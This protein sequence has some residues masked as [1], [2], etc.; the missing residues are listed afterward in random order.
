MKRILIVNNNMHIGGVQKS[1]LNLLNEIHADYDIT[2]LLFYNGGELLKDV[3]GDVK[4]I[5]P[6]EPLRYW[7]MFKGDAQNFRDRLMRSFWAGLTRVTGRNFSMRLACLFQKN[8]RGFD[9]AISFLHS[10]PVK[11]F[12]GGCNEFVLYRTD[13][14]RK[15]TFLHCDF[16]EIKA[17][18][19]Y[20]L[21]IYRQ[22]DTIAACSQGCRNAFLKVAPQ[23]AEKTVGVPN[24]QNYSLIRQMAKNQPVR[25]KDG[26]LN[27]VTVARFGREKGILRAIN[28]VAGLGNQAGDIRYYIIGDGI[29]YQEA[30]TLI[31]DKGL[32]D[33]VFLTGA[34]ENPYGYM[35][36]ADILLIPSVS[37]AA[38]MVVNE[39]ASLGTP[40]L[41]TETSSAVEMVQN[42]GFGW[43]CPNSR[44]GITE[45]IRKLLINPKEIQEK[46]NRIRTVNFNNIEARKKFSELI[47]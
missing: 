23:F 33:I 20:N 35:A 12:Y 43:V 45:G 19:K 11:M 22:Y 26:K 10:G 14:K 4:I 17:A 37:E 5:S 29:E 8:I 25:L 9:A 30:V 32:S 36:A 16:G 40:V 31:S 3:P 18:S 6:A 7:G 13:A 42:T 2:L 41:T 46:K 24:C 44:T 1:L 28:A 27:I 34:M 15:I 21:N 39:A 47:N 38:P